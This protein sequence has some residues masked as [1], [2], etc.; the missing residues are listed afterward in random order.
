[1]NKRIGSIG[2]ACV[3]IGLSLACTTGGAQDLGKLGGMIPGGGGSMT[4]GSMGNVAGLLQYCVKNNYLGGNSGASGIQSQLMGK[5]GG[6]GSNSSSNSTGSSTSDMLGKLTGSKKSSDSS[7][8]SGTN[9]P[10]YLNGA[11]GILQG[12][13]GQSTDLSSL[14][15]GNSD[16][17]SQLTTKVCDT[18]LKQGKSFLK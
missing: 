10:G 11:K 13:N 8:G 1:M 7:S 12:G 18:V 15:G 9:D 16:L 5:L 4:S 3:A 2:T 14:G 6:G 17:K